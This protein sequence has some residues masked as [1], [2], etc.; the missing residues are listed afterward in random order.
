M[1]CVATGRK[2]FAFVVFLFYV[3]VPDISFIGDA[4]LDIFDSFDGCE[5]RVVLVVVAVLTIAPNQEQVPEAICKVTHGIKLVIGTK[6]GWVG[7]LELNN[8][9]INHRYQTGPSFHR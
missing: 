1:F 5:H 8:C 6:V 9:S 3:D 7:F 2:L 4:I